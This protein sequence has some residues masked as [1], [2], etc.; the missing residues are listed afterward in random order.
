MIQTF[1]K[2]DAV[3]QD[4]NAHIHTAGTVQSWLQEDEGELQ[5]LPWPVQSPHLNI[6]EALWS[7][8]MTSVKNRFPPLTSVKQLEDVLQE[9]W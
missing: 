7:I 3:F 4:D 8:S 5:F 2:N 6:I 1:P 9:E